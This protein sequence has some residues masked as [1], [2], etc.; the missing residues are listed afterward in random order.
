MKQ[1]R[2]LTSSYRTISFK[3]SVTILYLRVTLFPSL[4]FINTATAVQEKDSAKEPFLNYHSLALLLGHRQTSQCSEDEKEKW[5]AMPSWALEYYY[6]LTRRSK[7]KRKRT[8][9]FPW[10]LVLVEL[11]ALGKN[12]IMK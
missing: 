4:L 6:H 10:V 3:S 8:T 7:W 1:V 11:F 9:V 5:L 12:S 2:T